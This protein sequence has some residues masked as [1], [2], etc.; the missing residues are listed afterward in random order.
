MLPPSTTELV[1]CVSVCPA[2][3]SLFHNYSAM[4][5]SHLRVKQRL[6]DRGRSRQL[7][8]VIAAYTAHQTYNVILQLH[9]TAMDESDEKP[10]RAMN[11]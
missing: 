2:A 3:R 1:R 4:L 5:N 10:R 8:G 9:T 11:I 7:G 6:S